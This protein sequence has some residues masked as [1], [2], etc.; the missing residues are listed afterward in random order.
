[1][2]R[3]FVA[4]LGG[5][6]GCAALIPIAVL[7][8]PFWAV[9]W[10]T[11]TLQPYISPRVVQWT[12]LIEFEP[13]VGWKPKGGIRAVCVA[14]KA[15]VFDVETDEEGWR[16]PASMDDSHVVVFGDSFA[17]GYAVNRPFFRVSSPTLKIK[18][19]AAQGYNMVQELLLMELYA[20]RLRGK[21]VVWFI[22]PGNDLT[23]NLSPSMWGYRSPLL[24]ECGEGW[25]IYTKHLNREKWPFHP[26]YDR[27]RKI[28]S[29]FGRNAASDRVY[30]ACEY[31]I[32]RGRAICNHA[33]AELVVLTIPWTL[34]YE[35]LP[36]TG[37]TETIDPD[38]PDKRF[39]ATCSKL[40]VKFISGRHFFSLDDYILGEG[41]LNE[42][43]HRILA[44]LVTR[45]HEEHCRSMM[46]DEAWLAPVSR[47]A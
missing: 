12:E 13:N 34:Q 18:A 36:W 2:L 30:D 23:D 43:G 47:N 33:G 1:M 31:L 6:L 14:P 45:L 28:S 15:D 20:S 42:K 40:G 8:T 37:V 32:E 3:M 39:A 16:G 11:R 22:Y 29:V 41:H 25:E 21:L 5:A 17:F 10:L 38:L 24:L 9:A 35:K 26:R 7:S 19:V 27:D 44:A 46:N 4:F